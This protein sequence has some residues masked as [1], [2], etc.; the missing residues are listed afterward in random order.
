MFTVLALAA[1][2]QND[3]PLP[4]RLSWEP[5]ATV[6]PWEFETDGDRDEDD[7]KQEKTGRRFD[8]DKPYFMLGARA[9]FLKIRDAEEGTWHGGA[10]ARLY[11]I[12]WLGIEGSVIVHQDD[13]ED[14]D[15]D[16]D[17]FQIPVQVSGLLYPWPDW[18]IQPYAMVGVGWYYTRI[19]FDDERPSETE[20]LFGV[21]V[22]AGLDLF[23]GDDISINADIRWVFV[24]DPDLDIEDERFDFWQFTVG[25]NFGV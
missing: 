18:P 6:S 8:I 10:A 24:N 16:I 19:D 11:L 2:L 3:T 21:H 12:E 9:G 22:G 15:V 20:H 25:I 1:M 7:D 14:R 5:V 23:L 4:T 17:V 13:F